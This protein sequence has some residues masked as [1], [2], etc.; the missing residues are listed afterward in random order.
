MQSVSN[1]R[2]SV[3]V[4]IT[5]MIIILLVMV[6]F[7]LDTGQLTFVRSQGQRAVDAAALAGTSAVPTGV[8]QEVFNRVTA[9]NT[10]GSKALNDYVGSGT[11]AN[12]LS[13]SHVTFIMYD[14]SKN[15]ITKV[16]NA[17]EANG[18]RVALED[19]NPYNGPVGGAMQSP[20]FLTPLLNLMG[21]S[22]SG[23]RNVTVSAVAYSEPIPGLP[24][25]LA[26]C[27]LE[28]PT[29]TKKNPNPKP[30]CSE[31]GITDSCT[32]TNGVSQC[33][34]CDALQVP[35]PK[36]NS[37]FT[38]Y[39]YSS[40]NAKS[41]KELIQNNKTC[42]AIPPVTLETPILLNNGQV[43]S[44]M[45]ELETLGPFSGNNVR[46]TSDDCYLVPVVPANTNCNQTDPIKKWARLCIRNVDTKGSPKMV[47]ADITCPVIAEQSR[48]T[49]CYVPKLIRDTKS[50]M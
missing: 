25:A 26:G 35:S 37:C 49:K 19:T 5:L 39:T 4:F 15:T 2:G 11:A 31:D 23:S 17:L 38:T 29:P 32:T 16:N 46:A 41:M 50:G 48:D 1:E 3:L 44:V 28:N 45:Q 20:L 12:K 18:V 42:G 6:G 36:D 30:T 10:T 8:D 21:S 9:F 34:K 22:T 13:S 27:P 40:S 7:G 24:I 47:L 43:N 33:Y 14:K